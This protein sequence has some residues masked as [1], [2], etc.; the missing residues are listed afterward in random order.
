MPIYRPN[1]VNLLRRLRLRRKRAQVLPASVRVKIKLEK[2][3][4]RQPP[5]YAIK[6]FSTF[7]RLCLPGIRDWI[8]TMHQQR[9]Q[10]QL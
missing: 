6:I 1:S 9:R 2:Y 5:R 4:Q 10:G 7:G 8:K 3:H